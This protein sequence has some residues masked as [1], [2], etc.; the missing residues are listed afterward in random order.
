MAAGS[1]LPLGLTLNPATGLLSGTPSTLGPNSF[2]ITV[3]DSSPTP[4]KASRLFSLTVSPITLAFAVQPVDTAAG[5][6]ISV[7]V[8]AQDNNANALSGI[9]VTLSLLNSNVALSGVRT[10]IFRRQ[11]P[12]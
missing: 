12:G 1:V 6:A 5:A 10:A 11:R 4:L 8:K 3:T 9:L 7:T 2:T